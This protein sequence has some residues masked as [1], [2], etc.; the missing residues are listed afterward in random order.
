[1]EIRRLTEHDAEAFWNIRQHALE[2]IASA[3]GEAAEE[4]R[5]TSI[6]QRAERLRQS[7][8]EDFVLGAFVD[9]KLIGTIGFYRGRQLKRSH[10]GN[11]WGMFVVESH[12][13]AGAGRAL[14]QE[15]IRVARTIPGLRC[16]LLSVSE[17]QG[18]ARRMY[19]SAGFRPWGVEPGALKVGDDYFDEEYMIL[20]L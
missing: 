4:H 10:K 5:E 6:A 19:I 15:A 8:D 9:S 14:L 17:T 20:D 16:I 12:R 1:M 2:S 18:A 13:G 3:F 7:S 11:I